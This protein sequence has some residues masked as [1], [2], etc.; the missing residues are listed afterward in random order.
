MK[1]ALI[2]RYG[3]PLCCKK[4]ES[5]I[6]GKEEKYRNYAHRYSYSCLSRRTTHLAPQ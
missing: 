5:R 3:Q 2:A 1:I 4:Q 6:A